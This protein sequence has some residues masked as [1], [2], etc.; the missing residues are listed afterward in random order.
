MLSAIHHLVT[1][2]DLSSLT[3]HLMTISDKDVDII[4]NFQK[5]FSHFV[6]SGQVWAL[7][8]GV[9]IGYMFRGFTSY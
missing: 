7:A 4:G 9:V 3:D 1:T 6:K 2:V 8:G 5:S